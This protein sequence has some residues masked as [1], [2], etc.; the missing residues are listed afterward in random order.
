MRRM[1]VEYG[2]HFW[3]DGWGS[4]YSVFGGNPLAAMPSLHFAT[5]LMAALLLAEVGPLRG[6]ARLRLR[7]DA[8]V[9]ARL[10]GRALR[11]R[12]ARRGGADGGACGARSRWAG[13]PLRRHRA[14]DRRAGGDG[15]RRR[16]ESGGT[17]RRHGGRER[18]RRAAAESA[19]AAPARDAGASRGGDAARA[20]S[21]GARSSLFARLRR[22]R[23]SA[24][25]TSSC[26]S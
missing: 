5:T 1:M 20:G 2:E 9:R 13:P 11:R 16:P 6:R 18:N 10:P 17:A 23:R 3:R 7:G 12:S 15:A 25:C 8:G 14:R 24:S 22:S 4:L 26:R 21:R 19:R